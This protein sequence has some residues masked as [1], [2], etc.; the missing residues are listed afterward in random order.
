MPER[1]Q[2]SRAKGWRMPADTI[3]VGRG[4]K[5][6]NPFTFANS[7][8]VHPAL[9]FACEVAPLLDVTPLCGKNLACWC[10]LDADCHADVLLELANDTTVVLLQHQSAP[11]FKAAQNTAESDPVVRPD[12]AGADTT[13]HSS[14]ERQSHD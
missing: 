2:R 9:R 5:W 7:G 13:L 6:G 11:A 10:S 4:S 1:I 14:R 12:C 8:H 3:Y